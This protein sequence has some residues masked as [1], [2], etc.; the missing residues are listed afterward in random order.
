MRK[1]DTEKRE[2]ELPREVSRI[3][4]LRQVGVESYLA[5]TVI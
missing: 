1:S 4:F 2:S 3:A 5:R